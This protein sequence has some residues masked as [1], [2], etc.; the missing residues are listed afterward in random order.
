MPVKFVYK[1]S[2][3]GSGNCH[4]LPRTGDFFKI[5]GYIFKVETVMFCQ[6]ACTTINNVSGVIYLADIMAETEKRLKYC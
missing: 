5:N 1:G 4:Q 2:I 6:E 3:C